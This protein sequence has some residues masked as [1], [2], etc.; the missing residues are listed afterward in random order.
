LNVETACGIIDQVSCN[1]EK[2]K[3]KEEWIRGLGK[4]PSE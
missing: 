4:M 3:G 1:G 2:Y